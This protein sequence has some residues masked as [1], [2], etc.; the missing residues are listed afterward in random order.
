[1]IQITPEPPVGADIAFCNASANQYVRVL[2]KVTP[3]DL[4]AQSVIQYVHPNVPF[5]TRRT[6]CATWFLVS[7]NWMVYDFVCAGASRFGKA[8]GTVEKVFHRIVGADLYIRPNALYLYRQS[9]L[10]IS[11]TVTMIWWRVA[12][13][14]VQDGTVGRIC[15][16]APTV[17]LNSMAQAVKFV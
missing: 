8:C 3:I 17:F 6:A 2:H 11:F 1:M 12:V 16:S 9:I 7:I 15:K 5:C 13:G 10:S 14:F 4:P